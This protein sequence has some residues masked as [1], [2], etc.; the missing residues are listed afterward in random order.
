[1]QQTTTEYQ[2][3]AP[4]DKLNPSPTASALRDNV[5]P[6]WITHSLDVGQPDPAKYKPYQTR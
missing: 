2:D 1:M 6:D 3:L 5:S 4:D